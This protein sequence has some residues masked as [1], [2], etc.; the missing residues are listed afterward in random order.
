MESSK[1]CRPRC[2][3]P[4]R[5]SKS[6]ICVYPHEH[7]NRTGHSV[8][9]VTDCNATLSNSKVHWDCVWRQAPNTLKEIVRD[10]GYP[11][12][13]S[14][15]S[16]DSDSL[17]SL[18]LLQ[19]KC[20]SKSMTLCWDW[21]HDN[22]R[23]SDLRSAILSVQG[24]CTLEDSV[25]LL[26]FTCCVYVELSGPW[27]GTVGSLLKSDFMMISCNFLPVSV[28][29]FLMISYDSSWASASCAS[30]QTLSDLSV[31]INQ[32]TSESGRL[33]HI[34]QWA[35]SWWVANRTQIS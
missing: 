19:C 16:E 20:R 17:I 10:T 31:N 11:E 15:R 22:P 8:S 6:E 32:V 23:S 29:P 3:F 1:A 5:S 13:S 7:G 4:K 35:Q 28:E 18:I 12:F 30:S 2:R 25:Q 26:F 33:I 34:W 21:E 24:A 27:S 14:P 9:S